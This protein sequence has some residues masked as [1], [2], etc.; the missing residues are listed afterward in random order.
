[1]KWTTLLL[2][3]LLISPS[4]AQVN[5]TDANGK[6]QGIWEK[7]YPG[8]RVYMYRGQFKDD[9]PVGKFSYF[10]KSSKVKAVITHSA[11]SDRS[12][13]Y[14][15]HETGGLMSYGIY[16]D[17][18]KD[19]V[20]VNWNM[21]G[22]LSSKESFLKDSLHGIKVV[23]YIPKEGDR[24]QRPSAVI[25]YGNGMLHGE[26]QEYFESGRI[27]VNGKYENH[28]KIGEWITYHPDGKK[29]MFVRYKKGVK[30]GWCYA[31]DTK[32]KESG[33]KY[34]YYGSLLEGKRLKE[35]MRQL[36]ELGVSP[37]E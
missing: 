35:K 27:K 14:Y 12:E 19:S 25:R 18:K 13:G 11:I 33:K 2:V 29:M 30:H 17:Q 20:W 1:M 9:K 15:Y 3:I 7:V 24:S 26:Y 22:K 16:Q 36:K 21:N 4:F 28:K 5:Q 23:Y 31:Y 6:K 8:T 32:G 10:Y 34:Y 37:N